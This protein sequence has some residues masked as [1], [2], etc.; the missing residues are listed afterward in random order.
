MDNFESEFD[1]AH[2]RFNSMFKIVFA[3]IAFVLCMVLLF[4]GIT[5]YVVVTK[6]PETVQRIERIGDAYADKLEQENKTNKKSE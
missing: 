4:W 3:F 5:A 1:K 6:G 2:K